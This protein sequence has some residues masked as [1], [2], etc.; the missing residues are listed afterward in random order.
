MSRGKRNSRAE[1]ARLQ[2]PQWQR[3][4]RGQEEQLRSPPVPCD[5]FGSALA[6]GGANHQQSIAEKQDAQSKAH[7]QADAEAATVEAGATGFF[8]CC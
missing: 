3:M 2:A 1:Q 6:G 8:L 4:Q 7:N 5:E